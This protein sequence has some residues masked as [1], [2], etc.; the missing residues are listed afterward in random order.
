MKNHHLIAT[1]ILIALI[2]CAETAF[3]TDIPTL[4][5]RKN[6][7]VFKIL[8][9]DELMHQ[10]KGVVSVTVD[11]PTDSKVHTYEGISLPVMLEQVFGKSWKE[12]DLVKFITMDGYQPVI[13]TERIIAASGVIST[14][15]KGYQGFRQLQRKNGETVNPGPFY[16]VWE[17]I[18]E[19]GSREDPWLSWP[20]Q[21]TSI[22]LTSFAREFPRSA[23]PLN[24]GNSANEGFL[25]F[26]QH[27]IKCHPINGDGGNV[28]PELNY[29]VNVTEYW[30]EEWLAR[31]IAD[32]QSIRTNSRMIPF[33]RDVKNHD[34][35]ILSIIAYLKVMKDKKITDSISV[36]IRER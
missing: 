15:E 19:K 2:F 32:P 35:V 12:F 29:P 9:P 34:A 6:D 7:R 3:A 36:K 5:L 1:W 31:F 30:K 21:I 17:N 20:W 18:S 22:E 27:C 33:Y 4:A 24:S 11:N 25:A 13:P 8:T 28:G 26:R 14:G 10:R 23:P 16:L